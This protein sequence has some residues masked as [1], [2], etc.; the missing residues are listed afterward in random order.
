MLALRNEEFYWRYINT[1]LLYLYLSEEHSA[2]LCKYVNE[3]LRYHGM[4]TSFSSKEEKEIVLLMYLDV[5]RPLDSTGRLLEGGQGRTQR[6]ERR[7]APPMYPLC[8]A[9][10]PPLN[11]TTPKK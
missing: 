11:K 8:P 2:C 7:T 1:M 4:E 6:S 5:Q 10:D 3:N 9:G